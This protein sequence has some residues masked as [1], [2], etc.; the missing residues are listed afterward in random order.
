[1]R[2]NL[3]GTPTALPLFPAFHYPNWYTWAASGPSINGEKHLMEKAMFNIK[4][5]KYWN[6]KTLAPILY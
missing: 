1:M 6:L 5:F 3:F 2:S 4:T